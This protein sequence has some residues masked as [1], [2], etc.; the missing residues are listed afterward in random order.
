MIVCQ[1]LI[2]AMTPFWTTGQNS[3]LAE[4]GTTALDVAGVLGKAVTPANSFDGV[5][6]YR[7]VSNLTDH[8]FLEKKKLVLESACSRWLSI[9]KL[10]PN[11]ST[12]SRLELQHYFTAASLG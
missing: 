2:L 5:S 1:F 3:E 12:T 8:S 7:A 11:S 4:K 6:F 9:L 10:C